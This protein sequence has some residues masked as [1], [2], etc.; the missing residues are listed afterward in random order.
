MC[1]ESFEMSSRRPRL[2]RESRRWAAL[3]ES[4]ETV[5]L[6]LFAPA[7]MAGGAVFLLRL[8]AGTARLR[9][10]ALLSG[11]AFA[12]LL[13]ANALRKNLGDDPLAPDI[14]EFVRRLAAVVAQFGWT[15]ALLFAVISAGDS[16]D[17][18]GRFDR[19][20]TL[21]AWARGRWRAPGV[22]SAARN[23]FLL[24]LLCGGAM[25]VAVG[26]LELTVGARASFQPRH[27]ALFMLNTVSPPAASL[28]YFVQIA[29]LE[30][31]GYRYFAGTWLLGLTRRQWL[32]ICL[33][34]LVYGLT[35]TTLGFLPPAE[36]FWAR[37]LV[38]TLVGAIWGLAFF[39]FDAL[40]VVLSHLTADLFI[41]NWPGI[42]RG[43]LMS[44]AAVLVPL[45]PALLRERYASGSTVAAGAEGDA[46]V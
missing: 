24:G 14:L 43:D 32:A 45:I 44:I 31:L 17:R 38:M 37:A 6:L 33:P 28:A 25:A 34:A 8:R 22:G 40:T 2:A 4:L 13:V 16:L 26:A 1:S 9:G 42:A 12:L 35:H 46:P 5:G 27:F 36:P 21:Q 23:G 18:E 3:G 30:E 15:F 11:G 10:P 41:F 29:L 7:V 20:T 39:R 19:G